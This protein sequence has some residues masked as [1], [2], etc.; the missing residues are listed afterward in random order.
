MR[1]L[2]IGGTGSVGTQVCNALVARDAHVRVL[3]RSADKAGQLAPPIEGVTGDLLRP[4]TL[5]GAFEDIDGVFL[6]TAVNQTETFEGLT[7]VNLAR[8]ADV[9]NIVYLSIHM[10]DTA[11]H[12]PNFGSKLPVE[13]AIAASGIPHTILRANTFY[14]NDLWYRD[15]LLEYGVYP[16][17]LGDVGVSHVDIRDIADAA[18]IAL[19]SGTA[20]GTCNLVG[21]EVHTGSDIAAIWSDALGKS[22]AYAGNDLDAWEQQALATLP[23]WTVFELKIMYAHIQR[24]GLIADTS[25][26]DKLS[27]LLG[28]PPRPFANFAAE[29]AQDWIRG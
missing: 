19:T 23:A 6:L 5:T 11:P 2:V 22:I 3:T 9:R 13:A 14:Q 8:Q 1:V 26:I 17:P 16:Q 20:A 12:I 7:V 24:H 27:S 4:E 25:D 15:V 29:A 10:A 28:H 18:A 21:P